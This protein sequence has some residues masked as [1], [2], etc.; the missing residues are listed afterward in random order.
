MTCKRFLANVNAEAKIKKEIKEDIKE[1]DEYIEDPV[2]RNPVIRNPVIMKPV[3]MKPVMRPA[4]IQET[5]QE[6]ILPNR[7]VTRPNKY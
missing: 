7:Q 4:T 1:L 2:I 3:I 6:K 5:I